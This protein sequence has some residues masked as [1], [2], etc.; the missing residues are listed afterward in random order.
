M[1]AHEIVLATEAGVHK[2]QSKKPSYFTGWWASRALGD[3]SLC[4]EDREMALAA[5]SRSFDVQMGT[6][7]GPKGG[8]RPGFLNEDGGDF[9]RR[10]EAK[11][12]AVDGPTC[13]AASTVDDGALFSVAEA[14][15]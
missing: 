15:A 4:D 14:S 1:S 7:K 3:P 12:R 8:I 6:T 10:A 13:V 2:S 9:L 11:R 5:Y